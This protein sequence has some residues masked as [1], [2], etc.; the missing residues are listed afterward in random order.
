M[1]VSNIEVREEGGKLTVK[2]PPAG[3]R[4]DTTFQGELKRQLEEAVKEQFQSAVYMWSG[5]G[6]N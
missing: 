1:T 6:R 5:T 4:P 3:R 2:L